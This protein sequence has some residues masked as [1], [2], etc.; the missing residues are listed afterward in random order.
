MAAEPLLWGWQRLTAA[1]TGQLPGCPHHGQITANDD[2]EI[3]TIGLGAAALRLAGLGI[4]VFPLKPGTKQPATE[5]GFKDATTGPQE[6][7][8]SYSHNPSANVGAA[9]GQLSRGLLI[10]D[11]D[12]KNGHDGITS[13]LDWLAGCGLSLPAAPFTTTPS[14]GVHVWL[15][16]P[17]GR[18][19]QSRNGLLPGV[20]LKADGGYV[21]TWPSGIRM[22]AFDPHGHRARE[23]DY[24]YGTYTWHGCPCQAP[25]APTGLLDALD[26]LPGT[27]NGN[28]PGGGCGDGWTSP[29]IQALIAG[30]IPAGVVQR[31]VL[32]DVI[33]K[34]ANDGRPEAEIWDTWQQIVAR[35]PLTDPGWPWTRKDFRRELGNLPRRVQERVMQDEQAA[36]AAAAWAGNGAVQVPVTWTGTPVTCDEAEQVYAKWLHDPDP[37]PTRLVLATYA[38][39]MDLDGD[40][41][42]MMEVGGSGIGKTERI[43]PL[44]SMPHVVMASTLTGEA[45]LL[46]ASPK[47]ERAKN[48]TGGVLRQIGDH[49]VLVV[50][51]FTSVLSM[52]RDQRSQVVAAMREIYDGRW[53]R[54][55]GTDGGQVLTWEGK[56][57]F[58]AG[59]TT[60]IDS[61]H[62]VL[63]AMGTRFL[64][65]RLPDA[66]PARIGRSALAHTGREREMR[67]ELAEVTTG[68]LHNLGQPHELH[69]GVSEWLLPLAAMA[70]QARSPVMRDY[71]GEIE[72]VGDAEAPTRIIKQLGQLWRACG[73]LGLDEAHSWAAVRRAGLD[74][75]PK[76]RRAV[77]NYLARCQW[78][79]AGRFVGS[80]PPQ[81]TTVVS[82]AVKHPSR[83]VRRTLEDLAAHGLVERYDEV[84]GDTRVTYRWALSAQAL[85]WWNALHN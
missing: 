19:V 83:T 35:T 42:W 26:Q 45:A 9:T 52:S 22:R 62:S 12:I 78:D 6:I 76:L 56:C 18:V 2:P 77:I 67:A 61:A 44:A 31:P 65:V 73:M 47:R 48:A 70:S 46:S 23:S 34:L 30:G 38:A 59:C 15:R 24:F 7:R 8:R 11:L 53:D 50:K 81:P 66:D 17:D 36:Q 85:T 16:V 5:H 54:Y 43:T 84:R 29:D 69:A 75:I 64:F 82:S 39:N 79:E 4:A 71:Q 25:Q 3:S 21:A 74:S 58:I 57:G 10:M 14:G 60:A 63:D 72:L 32:R 37:V 80:P 13:F 40:P 33:W 28:G 1:M 55:Y 49:G 51:D 27:S 68:L 20:D 41:V